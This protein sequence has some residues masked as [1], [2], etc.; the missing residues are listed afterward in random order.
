MQILGPPWNT[1]RKEQTEHYP[2]RTSKQFGLRRG[3]EYHLGTIKGFVLQT[4]L[5]T[6]SL[7]LHTGCGGSLP[8]D[9]ACFNG[10]DFRVWVQ[11]PWFAGLGTRCHFTAVG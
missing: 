1:N 3:L 5:K 11:G 7:V 8:F 2:Q 9:G 6:A 10:S 4:I